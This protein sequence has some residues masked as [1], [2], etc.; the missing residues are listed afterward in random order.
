M[1]RNPGLKLLFV[2]NSVAGSN[3]TSW[4]DIISNYFTEKD[5]DVDYFFLDK[6]PDVEGLKKYISH[7]KP[8]KVIAVGGDGTVTL[9]ARIVSATK[10]ALGILPAGSANG[11][12]KELN[13]PESAQEALAIIEHGV[14]SCCD[15]IKIN[16][17]DIIV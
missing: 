7:S 3:N 16:N 15:A 4:Q 12:A 10:A 17:K 11:M 6:D 2:I 8:D 9:V 5:F 1:D 14:I 13:I